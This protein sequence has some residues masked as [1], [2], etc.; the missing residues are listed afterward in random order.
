MSFRRY[1]RNGEGIIEDF[2]PTSVN[3][4]PIK[5]L[6][7]FLSDGIGMSGSI[8]SKTLMLGGGYTL[9]F[10]SKTLNKFQMVEQ[11]DLLS[12]LG[13]SLSKKKRRNGE[14]GNI[15]MTFHYE[16]AK[17]SYVYANRKVKTDALPTPPA[18][19]FF[20]LTVKRLEETRDIPKD[21]PSLIPTSPLVAPVRESYARFKANSSAKRLEEPSRNSSRT[22]S[23]P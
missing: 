22:E 12:Y 5:I 16:I 18:P 9:T 1:F 21:Q 13:Y 10:S 15:A 8:Y 4:V 19:H 11:T 23:Q 20:D 7:A 3:R 14:N 17:T 6:E 2:D